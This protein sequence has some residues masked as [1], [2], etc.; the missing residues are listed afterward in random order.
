MRS[1]KTGGFTLIELLIVIAIIGILAAVL[2]PNLL[3]AR[4]RA[5]DTA[6]QTC[7]KEAATLQEVIRS[8][9]PFNYRA[10]TAAELATL[11]G[12]GGT[13]GVTLTPGTISNTTF[14]YT[15]AH[16]SGSGTYQV[17]QGGGVTRVLAAP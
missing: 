7:L 3:N 16:S 14:A 5:F 12:C 11:T 13:T 6:S 2:I 17:S 10:F 8:D 4:A 15:A 9:S 1:T